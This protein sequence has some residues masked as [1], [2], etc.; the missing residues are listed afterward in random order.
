M[1]KHRA[2]YLD[3]V[4]TRNSKWRRYTHT[5]VARRNK[6]RA[7]EYANAMHDV[8][9]SDWAYY[10]SDRAYVDSYSGEPRSVRVGDTRYSS[11]AEFL[12]D[13]PDA[14]SY[15]EYC[16]DCRLR[17]FEEEEKG[18]RFDTYLNQG[19]CE[20]RDLAVKLLDKTLVNGCWDEVVILDAEVRS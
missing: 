11:A 6:E 4:F 5:V 16:R 12:D 3:Q 1:N 10:C 9:A 18:G 7:F 17:E 19:W 14:N 8:D 13:F 20:R 2:T 15:Q